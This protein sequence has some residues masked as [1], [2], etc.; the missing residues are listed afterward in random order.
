MKTFL[1]SFFIL[2]ALLITTGSVSAQAGGIKPV[3]IAGEVVTVEPGA[4]KIQTKDGVT[5][6]AI[7]DKT[8]FKKVSPDNPTSL[9][10]AVS[11]E[12]DEIETGDKV[13]V[14][15]IPEPGTSIYPART[16]YLMSKSELAQKR[17]KE[18][19]RWATRG[20]SGRVA[21][22]NMAG[23]QIT[24]EIRGLMNTTSVVVTPKPDAKIKRYRPN[25]ISYAEALESSIAEIKP[26]DMFRAVGDRS[27]DGTTFMAEEIITG[28]FQTIVGTVK[29]IDIEKKEILLEDSKTKKEIAVSFREFSTVKRFPEEMLQR[30][31]QFGGG[32]G[33]GGIRPAGAPAQGQQPPQQPQQT[34]QGQAGPPQQNGGFMGRGAGGPRGGIDDMYERLPA[35]SLADLKPGDV[36]AVSAN[37]TEPQDKVFAIKVLAGVGPLLAVAQAQTQGRGGRNGGVGGFTIPGLEGFDFGN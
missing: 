18:A 8:Q 12:I 32:Q 17:A 37:K 2:C 29:S 23:N 3:L 28:A 14:S 16:I 27:P 35:I 6:A 5:T 22:V 25:S 15:A 4:I 30:M 7:N 11:V 19:E 31:F 9:A 36:I 33:M 34:P 21:A 10:S 1:Y 13:V 20:I 26:G 24:V